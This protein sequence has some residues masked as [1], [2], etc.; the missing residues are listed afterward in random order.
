MKKTISMKLTVLSGSI[1]FAGL[2]SGAAIKD[3][4]SLGPDISNAVL[5]RH[6]VGPDISNA[7]AD[8]HANVKGTDE[9]VAVVLDLNQEL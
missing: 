9:V 1:L 3:N 5:E 6:S 4:R 2:P 8:R 7:T